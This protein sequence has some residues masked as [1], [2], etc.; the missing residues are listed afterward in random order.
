MARAGNC[1]SIS[2]CVA[3]RVF[4]SPKSHARTRSLFEGPYNPNPLARNWDVFPHGQRFL[5][6]EAKQQPARP[7]TQMILVLNWLDELKAR[8]PRK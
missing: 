8:V 7:I 2:R 3:G 1:S 4:S 6:I 5:M